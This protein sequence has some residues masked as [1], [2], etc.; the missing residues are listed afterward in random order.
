MRKRSRYKPKATLPDPVNWVLS[1][2]KPLRAMSEGT[3]LKIKNHESMLDITRGS[4]T[5]RS[6]D[7]LVGAM[8]MAEALHRVNPVLGED[9]TAEIRE[10][11]DAVFAMASRGLSTGKF[12]FTGAEMQA[13]NVGMEVHDAQLDAC[14]VGELEKAV[15][16]MMREIQARRARV[17]A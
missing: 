1:G 10:A 14:T 4:G 7:D 8:N 2:M 11:Q 12:L 13:V 15:Q 9:Y 3:T 17:I 5:R 16:L 6:V